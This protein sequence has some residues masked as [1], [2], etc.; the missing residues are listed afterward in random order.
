MA[1]RFSTL[2]VTLLAL[3]PSIALACSTLGPP[4]TEEEL[5]EKASTVFVAHIIKT[6]EV[7][8]SFPRTSAPTTV[9]E[10]EGNISGFARASRI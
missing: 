1:S 6:E 5:F 10:V 3:A 8:V 7:T 9:P 4:P 2:L